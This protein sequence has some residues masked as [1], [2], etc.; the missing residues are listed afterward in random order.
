MPKFAAL[1]TT[2]KIAKNRNKNCGNIAA[3]LTKI[4]VLAILYFYD[5]VIL[6][7]DRDNFSYYI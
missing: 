7:I 3:K 4:S 5:K 2:K 6:R 1:R